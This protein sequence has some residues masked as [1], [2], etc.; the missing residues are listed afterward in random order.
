MYK[1]T[2][3][4]LFVCGTAMAA[5][6]ES[7]AFS[8]WVRDTSSIEVRT[9][10]KIK[11]RLKIS[12]TGDTTVGTVKAWIQENEGIPVEQQSIYLI[13][14]YYLGILKDTIELSDD[15]VRLKSAMHLYNANVFRLAIKLPRSQS[16]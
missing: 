2:L 5:A 1:L 13:K 7:A 4:S 14:S 9:I 11:D 12:I 6:A 8:S 15:T 16:R 10:I 3:L